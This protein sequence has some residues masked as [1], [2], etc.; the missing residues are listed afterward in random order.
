MTS[1]WEAF[2]GL[3]VPESSEET[4][5]FAATHGDGW[6]ALVAKDSECRPAILIRESTAASGAAPVSLQNLRVE[7]SMLC[8]VRREGAVVDEEDRYSIINC[9]AHDIALQK[10][11]LGVFEGTL[12]KITEP[13]SAQLIT[14]I[15]ERLV[16]MFLA[17]AQ[18]AQ[19][20]VQ[21]LWAELFVIYRSSSPKTLVEAWH[22]DPTEIHDFSL[23]S[24]RVEVKSARGPKREHHFTLAQ[25]RPPLGVSATIVSLLVSRI[26]GGL[27]LGSLWADVRDAVSGYPTLR[28]KVD[29]L[30]MASLGEA[31]EASRSECFDAGVAARSLRLYDCSDIPSV[32]LPIPHGV[33]DVRFRADLT[34]VEASIVETRLTPTDPL[35][36]ACLASA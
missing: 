21:G 22:A 25:L 24:E 29:Q 3:S 9:M 30:C 16:S 17:A 18:P 20:N 28:L 7:H 1:L 27:S 5:S 14:E 13:P 36:T 23:G 32:E 31:W 35:A 15:V 34:N 33:S 6:H 12:M 4:L 26:A 11:F 19:R 10:L 8:R 2:T